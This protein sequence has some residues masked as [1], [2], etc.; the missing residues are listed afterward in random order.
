MLAGGRPPK[1]A[2]HHLPGYLSPDRALVGAEETSALA[3]ALKHL[4]TKRAAAVEAELRLQQQD[5]QE[6][7]AQMLY[8]A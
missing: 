3:Q 8:S 2:A 7:Q 1:A 5:W 6:Q 4:D